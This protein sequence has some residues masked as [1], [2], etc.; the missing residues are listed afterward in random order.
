MI[1]RN[2]Q[3]RFWVRQHLRTRFAPS[4]QLTLSQ[5]AA[6][7]FASRGFLAAAGH[8]AA[9]C[10][11]FLLGVTSQPIDQVPAAKALL[12]FA[13]PAA[14]ADR[15]PR[16]IGL[17]LQRWT[18]GEPHARRSGAARRRGSKS[19]TPA[20]FRPPQPQERR[21]PPHPQHRAPSTPLLMTYPLLQEQG[22]TEK[23]LAWAEDQGTGHERPQKIRGE[24]SHGV[25][26]AREGVRREL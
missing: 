3:Q 8:D 21:S 7:S 24:V 18:R 17:C 19:L 15:R 13:R 26:R 5:H 9:L 20:S 2:V 14:A 12:P 4:A 16:L 22:C 6:P 10:S 25:R 23:I 1:R 11:D